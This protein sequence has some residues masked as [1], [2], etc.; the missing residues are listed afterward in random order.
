MT[1]MTAVPPQNATLHALL[2][3][4]GVKGTGDVYDL[5]GWQLHT[6]PD[7]CERLQSLNPHCYRGAFG[8]PVLATDRG[9]WFGVAIGTSTLA[10]RLPPDEAK[11]AGGRDF[12]NAGPDWVSVD[13]W[14]TDLDT[15]KRWARA[16]L[17]Q[18]T[19]IKE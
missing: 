9:V 12:P 18:A 6:H 19:L 5:D 7:L 8:V 11:A 16:A 10:L 14:Q 2:Q 4:Q 3:K 13:P 1:I 15:L 17:K